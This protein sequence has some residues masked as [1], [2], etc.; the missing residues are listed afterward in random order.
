MQDVIEKQEEKALLDQYTRRSNPTE[1]EKPKN[2]HTGFVVKEAPWSNP[3]T[4]EFPAI[5]GPAAS[6]KAPTWGPS[7]LGPKL[8]N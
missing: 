1:K 2:S 3:G 4:E 8:P 7:T 5:G 6:Q